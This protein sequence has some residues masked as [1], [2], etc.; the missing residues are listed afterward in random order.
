VPAHRTSN[1]PLVMALKQKG[2]YGFHTGACVW[3]SVMTYKACSKKDRTF[4]IKTLLLILQHFKHRPLQS[5][6][7]YWRYTVPSVSS[8]VGMLP[9]THFL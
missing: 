5:S 1:D 7:L 8:T 4:A 9:G 6:P 3:W 2:K